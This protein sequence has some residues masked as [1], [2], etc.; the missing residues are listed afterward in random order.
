MVA[1][2]HGLTLVAVGYPDDPGEY[3][4]RALLTRSRRRQAISDVGTTE[5]QG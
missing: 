2:P 1:P 3:A 4:A 5:V